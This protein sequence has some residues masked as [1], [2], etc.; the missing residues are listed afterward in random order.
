MKIR[1]LFA[2]YFISIFLAKPVLALDDWA[3][4]TVNNNI[5]IAPY[6]TINSGSNGIALRTNSGII[7]L[8]PHCLINGDVI[9]GPQ[10]QVIPGFGSIITGNVYAAQQPT[11]F[12]QVMVP[13]YLAASPNGG[14]IHTDRILSASGKFNG[15]NLGNSQTLTINGDVDLYITGDILLGNS[16]Q[17][18]INPNSSLM[19]YLGG[20]ILGG[21]SNGF[22]NLTRN[23]LNLSIYA[24]NSSTNITL[25]NPTDLYGLFYA[26]SAYVD[27]NNGANVYGMLIADSFRM[28]NG[29][30]FYEVPEPASILILAL[31]GL[32]LLKIKNRK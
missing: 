23:S 6:A 1:R 13:D 31:G 4:I 32:L 30:V 28:G 26:P 2:I 7:N 19:L 18:I 9:I 25:R 14:I 29:G 20:D 15:I 16:A 11:S 5:D 3:G 17:F 21:N 10:G 24:L 27:L 12:T 8:R 22:N